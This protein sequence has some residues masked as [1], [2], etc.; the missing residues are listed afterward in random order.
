MKNQ[1]INLECVDISI[2]GQGI[3][4]N[5]GLVVFVKEMLPGEIAD[6]KIIAEK[7]NMAFGII[8]KLIKASPYRIKSDC[9]IA[10]KCGGCD[11]RYVDYDYTLVLKKKTLESTFRNMN[12]HIND[13]LKCDNPYFYRNKV[14]VPVRNHEF[15]FYRKFSNDIVEFD[16]CFIQ[17]EL[18]NEL[19]NDVKK[20]LLNL[21]IDKY[22]RHILIKHGVGTNELMLALIVSDFNVPN[23]NEFVKSITSLYSNIKSII[24]NLN[25]RDDNVILGEEEKVLFGRDYIIDE[26]EGLKFKIALKS[27]YQV[28][29]RQMIKLYSLARDLAN[30]D[31]KTR[32]LDLFSGIGTISLFMA[33]Y[34]KEVTGVEIVKEAVDNAI[35]NAKLNNIDNATFYLDDARCDLTKYLKDKDVVIV[36]PPRKGLNNDLIN[37]IINSNIN[38]IVYISCNPATL[39]RDL[40]EFEGKYEIGDIN[41]VDMFPYTTHVE[42]VVLMSRVAEKGL[43]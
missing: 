37:S 2:D 4:K 24:L 19:F 6:V 30:V 17:T 22:V 32:L 29:Y 43:K 11:Y 40:K 35:D 9:P 25:K 27:F 21:K 38:K 41:P 13:I 18:S 36:D 42:T 7:K 34:C 23:L 31:K 16:K 12:L 1:I 26:F 20:L 28:N 39:A 3:C 14:Q 33:K 10:Y 15:G 8:D 5:D